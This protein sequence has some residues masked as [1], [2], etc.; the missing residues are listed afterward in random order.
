MP[1]GIRSTQVL[2]ITGASAK[3]TNPMQSGQQYVFTATVDCW[4]K[5]TT[6]GG[7]A[8][9]ATADNIFYSAGQRLPLQSPDNAGVTTNAFVHA[10]IAT[11]MPSGTACLGVEENSL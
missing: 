11:G 4:V 3:F 1:R 8:A 2:A 6:T 5:V 7:S 10:I 9:V